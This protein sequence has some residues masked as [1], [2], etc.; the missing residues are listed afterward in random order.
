MVSAAESEAEAR[1]FAA[2]DAARTVLGGE[3]APRLYTPRGDWTLSLRLFADGW[4]KHECWHRWFGPDEPLIVEFW[5]ASE[6]KKVRDVFRAPRVPCLHSEW[7]DD[8]KLKECP[9]CRALKKWADV[10]SYF[11]G[12]AEQLRSRTRLWIPVIVREASWTAE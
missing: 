2:C 10:G 4:D 11:E 9:L 5:S 8:G 3:S 12:W 6:K 7:G 1:I